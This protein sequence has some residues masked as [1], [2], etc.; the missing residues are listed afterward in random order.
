MKL[1]K[2]CLRNAKKFILKQG[3]TLETAESLIELAYNMSRDS[4][5]FLEMIELITTSLKCY[6]AL[7]DAA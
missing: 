3:Y 1:D 5:S 6:D 4:N 2:L 7:Q